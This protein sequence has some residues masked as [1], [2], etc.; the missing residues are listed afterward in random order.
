MTYY[1]KTTE[2]TLEALQ[3]TDAGLTTEAVEERQ[4]IYGKNLITIKGTPLWRKITEPFAN[5]FVAILLTAAILSILTGHHIDAII[6]GVIIGV[7]AIIYYV[8]QMST[9]RVLKALKHHDIQQVSTFRN[10]ESV[11]IDT[12]DLVPG[13]CFVIA[14]GEKVPADARILHANNVR[15]DEAM[16]TG[17][18]LPINK[19]VHALKGEHPIYERTNILFQGSFLVSGRATAVVTET[20]TH[21][22]FG[23]LASLAAPTTERSPVQ[24]KID[25]LITRLIIVVGF[26]SIGVFA[27]AVYRGIEVAEAL[28]FVL[29][30]AVSAVPEG[31]PVAITVI[32]VLGMRRLARYKALARSM[33]A[34]ETI[35]ILTTIA[36]DKTGTLTKNKLSVQETWVT[37]ESQTPISEWT[38]LATNQSDG[39]MSDP[40]DTALRDFAKKDN[41]HINGR[42]LAKGLPFDQAL[43]MSGNVWQVGSTYQLVLKGVPE[44][45]IQ[46]GLAHDTAAKA[47]AEKT[48]HHFTGLGYRVIALAEAPSLKNAP[49]SLNDIALSDI[50]FI[51]LIAVADELRPEAKQAINTA[52]AAGITVRMIT[53]D[54]AETA[55]AIG[56]K[57]G[58]IEHR[59]QVMDCRAIESLSDEELTQ[60]ISNIRVFARVIPEAKHRI[61]SIL[62]L[63]HITAMTGDG[64]NDVPA[65]TNAHVGIAMGS[66]AQV[67][68]EAGDIVLL[69]NNFSSIV[70]AVEGGRV[71]NDNIRRILFYVFATSLGEV[72]IMI[73]A[74]VAGLPLPVVAVQI[75]WI[76]L[77]TDT[78][79]AIPLG[80]EPAEDKVMERPPRRANQPILDGV[81][82]KRLFIMA[83]SMAVIGIGTFWYFLQNHNVDY[84]RTIAFTTL[85][86][87]QWANAVNARSEFASLANRIR[88][89][90]P[91]FLIGFAIAVVLQL[92]ALFGPLAGPLYVVPVA[93]IDIIVAPLIGFASLIIISELHKWHS[94]R[95]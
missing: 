27:L 14:E 35:G 28:R 11:Q 8:Q 5:V 75:L 81:L 25:H 64:V 49:E 83:G 84:A 69:D 21:T 62:K 29:A 36:S 90:N 22:E 4:R 33:K 54:H 16:L 70:K 10:G 77:V 57:L 23:R 46:H 43:A 87:M 76:N 37:K 44:K 40:L 39:G 73:T 6:I 13:D 52:T 94:R 41:I 92:I 88:A 34:V 78:A 18:S 95:S 24:Q 74:L 15:V 91:A 79:F 1:T 50:R 3:V 12:E 55:Y 47:V 17:E 9:E 53:G 82:F 42:T 80:V 59:N 68:K 61:L 93:P 65:L 2:Q 31:L 86:V 38:M 67:A 89:F 7:S 20:G 58:L 71:I 45:I 19:H 72:T 32:L 30:L 66:G 26:V 56:K 60:K 85:V 51:G 48:L 63:S